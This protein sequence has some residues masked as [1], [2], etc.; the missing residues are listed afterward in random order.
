MQMYI[1]ED[2][3]QFGPRNTDETMSLSTCRYQVIFYCDPNLF[4]GIVEL[5]S[6]SRTLRE[7]QMTYGLTGSFKDRPIAEWLEKYNATGHS[8]QRVR[9]NVRNEW[10]PRPADVYLS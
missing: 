5:V 4:T 9:Y 7:I 1:Y 6:D 3:Q 8:Y 2:Q 10:Y